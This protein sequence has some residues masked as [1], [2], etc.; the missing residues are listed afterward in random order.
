MDKRPTVI[1]ANW[2]M[3]KTE[4]EASAFV[5]TLLPKLHDIKTLIY[6][7]VP[8]TLIKE[9]SELAK[10]TP[11]VIGAQNMH[12]AT[13][14]AFTGEIAAKMLIDA[15]A[16]FVLLGHSERRHIFKES[17][18]FINRKVKKAIETGLQPVLCVG[19]TLSERQEGRKDEVLKEQLKNC[20]FDLKE[21]DLQTLMLAY[22]PVWAVGTNECA[23]PDEAES[24][25]QFCR[26]WIKENY[27]EKLSQKVII[28]YGG[29][30]KPQNAKDLLSEPNIDGLLVGGCSLEEKSFWQIIQES[31]YS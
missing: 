7:A 6:L 2:K 17:N 8:F 9:I 30:V 22:E 1:T 4:V 18:E 5:T 11:L 12:D 15:G 28:Q 27:S 20:L 31:I 24:A 3:Y 16:Q 23:T 25:H 19:E 13:E 21:K 29:S 14:G 26:N 10:D